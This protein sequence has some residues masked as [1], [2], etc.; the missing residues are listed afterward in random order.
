M[1]SSLIGLRLPVQYH[2]WCC[3]RVV[4]CW[5][6]AVSTIAVQLPRPLV[7]TAC[8]QSTHAQ[9]VRTMMVLYI[10]LTLFRPL[11]SH[12]TSKRFSEANRVQ[13]QYVRTVHHCAAGAQRSASIPFHANNRPQANPKLN[14]SI[15]SDAVHYCGKMLA[16][17]CLRPRPEIRLFYKMH[18]SVPP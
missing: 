1:L 3:T 2:P 17:P 10:F 5:E 8:R 18:I 11:Y 13:I 4:P 7:L 16:L 6:D 12:Y 15:L 9:S 14:S